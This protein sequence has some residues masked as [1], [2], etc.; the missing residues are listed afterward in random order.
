METGT[1]VAIVGIGAVGLLGLMMVN[2][3]NARAM[4]ASVSTQP[5]APSSGLSAGSTG[6]TLFGIFTGLG[7]GIADVATAVGA[8]ERASRAQANSGKIPTVLYNGRPIAP[9][10][11]PANFG[12]P[13]VA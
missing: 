13:V 11:T 10:N 2:Q 8:N 5:P 3:M 6:E 4:Q 12:S 1:V 9:G 7:R